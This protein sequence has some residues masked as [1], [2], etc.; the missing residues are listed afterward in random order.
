[1]ASKTRATELKRMRR[2]AGQGRKR[3]A[4]SRNH[5]TTPSQAKLFG[6]EEK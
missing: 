2:D 3:K 6:D 1:M 5:G 4:K